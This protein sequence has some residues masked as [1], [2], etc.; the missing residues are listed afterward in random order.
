ML[1]IVQLQDSDFYHIL[2]KIC[3]YAR[4]SESSRFQ[5]LNQFKYFKKHSMRVDNLQNKLDY[6]KVRCNS[7]NNKE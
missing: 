1:N 4:L 2:E 5:C 3:I 7:F 6:E